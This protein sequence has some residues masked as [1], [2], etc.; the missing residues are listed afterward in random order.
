VI[1]GIPLRRSRGIVAY[2]H[3]E[4]VR[5]AQAMLKPVPEGVIPVAVASSPSARTSNS[6]AAG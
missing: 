3:G 4:A 1:E 2:G 6:R 5:I